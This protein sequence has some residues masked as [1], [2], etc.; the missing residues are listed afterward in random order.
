MVSIQ[1]QVTIDG[2]DFD[3]LS[4]SMVRYNGEIYQTYTEVRNKTGVPTSTAYK[5]ADHGVQKITSTMG[6]GGLSFDS[7]S[8]S[9]DSIRNSLEK[10]ENINMDSS[11]MIEETP[12]D[13]YNESVIHDVPGETVEQ[14]SGSGDVTPYDED[15]SVS[16]EVT[17]AVDEATATA[18]QKQEDETEK[19]ATSTGSPGSAGSSQ[20]AGA[21][22]GDIPDWAPVAALVALVAWRY[23]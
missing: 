9:S 7:T 3:V 23:A 8:L 10:G 14:V 19:K 6:A 17:D 11:E 12:G 16:D 2:Y 21:G 4:N 18:E 1:K 20:S 15:G 22:I 5:L 13:T